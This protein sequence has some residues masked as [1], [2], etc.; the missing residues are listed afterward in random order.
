MLKSQ[1]FGRGVNITL[2]LPFIRTSV[3]TAPRLNWRD[4]AKP[5]SAVFITALNLAIKMIVNT[6]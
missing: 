1:G 6:Q 5:M 2:G 3:T 4:V